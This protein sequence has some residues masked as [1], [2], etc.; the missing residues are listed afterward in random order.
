MKKEIII[1]SSADEN[2]IAIIEDG[3]LAELF[4]ENEEYERVIGDIYLG[5][6]AKVIPGIKAAFIDL[7]FKQD[8][9][10][11]FSDVGD[12]AEDMKAILGTDSEIDEDEDDEEDYIPRKN[13]PQKR[14]QVPRLERGQKIIVQ[15]TKEPVGNKGVRVTSKVSIPGRYLVFLPFENKVNASKQIQNMREKRRLKNIVRNYRN[16]KGLEFGAIIRTVAEEQDDKAIIEDLESIYNTWKNIE[17]QVKTGVPPVLLYK[18]LTVTTSVIRDL[19]RDDVEILRTDN[20][21]LFK[22]I[23]QYVKINSP[24]L[25]DKIELYKGNKALFDHY[26]IE[27]EIHQTLSTR[28]QLKLGGHLVIEKTEAMYVIDVNSG[29]YAK[30]KD[31]ETNSLKTNLEASREIVRQI[32]LRDLGGIIVVD[33]IDVYDDKNKKK[34]YDELKKEFKRDRA[35]VTILPMSE[36]GLVQI[37]RQRVRENV[38]RSITEQCPLCGGSGI[39][40]SSGNITTRIERWIKRYKLDKHR[41]S[42]KLLLKVHPMVYKT[43]REGTISNM[44]KLAFKHLLRITLEEDSSLAFQDFRFIHAKTG[45]DITPNYS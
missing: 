19:F 45:D 35:K 26:N 42:G 34:V 9:F 11:H 33:F 2:R 27:P 25:L 10:L 41:P 23:Q 3:K 7:G 39:I 29:K 30:S 4:I 12:Q 24:D 40:E 6:V 31:Q 18:D 8:A 38:V 37:T 5:K 13:Q 28:V 17:K 15:I 44:T 36:F 20:K 16:E 22:E 32:R 1:N 43:L 21:K 14:R